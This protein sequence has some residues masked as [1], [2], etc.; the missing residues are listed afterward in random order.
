MTRVFLLRHGQ[1]E[2]NAVGRL[3]GSTDIPLNETGQEQAIAA[4]R[5]LAALVAPDTMI[6]ASP[7]SRAR[8][9]AQSLAAAVGV[10]V[11]TD[12]RL[13]ERSYGVWEGMT[14]AE[15]VSHAPDEVVRWRQ[16]DEPAIDGY[17]GHAPLGARVMAALHE[18]AA[19]AKG[20]L[21]LVSHGGALRMAVTVA[22]GLHLADSSQ[23]AAIRGLDNA[24]WSQLKYRGPGD[25]MLVAHNVG[26]N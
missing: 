21:V 10:S 4:A 15:R 24:H 11:A 26:P 22:L 18:H 7:L 2:W 8:E 25:W 23:R 1:T 5:A 19:R 12:A 20:D 13:A 3:Q 9:T 16:G 14:D 6:V 17:E